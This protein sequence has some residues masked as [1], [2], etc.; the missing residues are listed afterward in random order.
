MTV[1]LGVIGYGTRVRHVVTE[2]RKADPSCVLSAMCD[3]RNAEIR[4]GL[5]AEAGAVR[6][7]DSA[8]ELLASGV[9]AVLIGTRC[10]LHAR[11][12][13]AVI[14]AGLPLFLEKPVATS[15]EDLRLLVEAGRAATAGVVVSFPLRGTAI[16]QLAAEIVARA[17]LAPWSTCRR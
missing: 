9:N 2:I 6:F 4:A 8:E 15:Y 3:P 5:G 7:C 11:L 12:A 10:S 14:R 16:V 17:G 13:V 1:K